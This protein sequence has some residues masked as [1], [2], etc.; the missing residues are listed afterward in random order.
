MKKPIDRKIQ[1]LISRYQDRAA[2]A[3]GDV[4]I[5]EINSKNNHT[6]GFRVNWDRV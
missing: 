2:I 6:R 3:L 1:K 4:T 5:E